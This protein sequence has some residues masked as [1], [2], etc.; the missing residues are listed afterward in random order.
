[1]ATLNPDKAMV[2][3]LGWLMLALGIF[4]GPIEGQ[5]QIFKKPMTAPRLY[6]IQIQ[7]EHPALP[8]QA[9]KTSLIFLKEGKT[10]WSKNTSYLVLHAAVS[11]GNGRS[12]FELSDGEIR[13]YDRGGQRILTQKGKSLVVSNGGRYIA[14]T[15]G[16]GKAALDDGLVRIFD[17]DGWE[18]HEFGIGQG[19]IAAISDDD[20]MILV[21]N[22]SVGSSQCSFSV[23]SSRGKLMWKKKQPSQFIRV[24]GNG[25]WILFATNDGKTVESCEW[26]SGKTLM[27]MPIRRFNALYNAPPP[28]HS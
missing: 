28:P 7:T 2:K 6:D 24:E 26:K 3:R 22:L 11:Q 12:F 8:D 23:L 21:R 18:K 16:D 4:M 1:M 27:V 20:A 10:Q 25:K 17:V 13:G 14:F 9:V 19:S 15:P 5:A